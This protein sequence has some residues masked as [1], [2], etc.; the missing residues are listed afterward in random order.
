MWDVGFEREMGGG[1]RERERRGRKRG[2][3]ASHTA[4]RKRVESGNW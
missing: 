4:Q 3:S 2:L 1:R